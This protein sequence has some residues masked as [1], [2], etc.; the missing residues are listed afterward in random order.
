MTFQRVTV[1]QGEHAISSMPSVLLTTVLGSCV[2]TCLHDPVA[3]TGGMN[4]FLLA[5]ARATDPASAIY[6]VHAMEILINA[7]MAAGADR[8][9]LR[10][11]VY[12]GASVVDGIGGNIGGGNATFAREFLAAEGI[13]IVHEDVGGM[14]ARRVEFLPAEGKSRRWHVG[15]RVETPLRP[16]PA[17]PDPGMAGI[18]IF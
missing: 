15:N 5:N 1:V 17:R 18:E 10:A 13:P 9:R 8:R 7:L 14:N 2:A 16:A 3:K 12:G 6:G 4:H 11:H